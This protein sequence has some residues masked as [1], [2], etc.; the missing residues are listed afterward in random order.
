MVNHIGITN[1][2][3][4]KS[5]ELDTS[6]INLFIGKPNV[7]KSNLLE[8]LSF[9]DNYENKDLRIEN[10][11]NLFYDQDVKNTISIKINNSHQFI[12]FKSNRF[13]SVSL[14]EQALN[15]KIAELK[16]DFRANKEAA[17]KIESISEVL[18]E[19]QS[20]ELFSD[21]FIN[22]LDEVI[23]L[24]LVCEG[25]INSD[26]KFTKYKPNFVKHDFIIKKYIFNNTI[27]SKNLSRNNDYLHLAHPYGE[28][29]FDLLKNDRSLLTEISSFFEE[30][31]YSLIID[32]VS[33][34]AEIQKMIGNIGYK[35]PYSLIADTLQ[36]MVFYIA[37]IR[38]NENTTILLEEPENHSFPPYIRDIAFE[39]INSSNQFFIATHSPYLLNTL[40]AE[41]DSK[42]LSINIVSLKN[43]KT[44]VKTIS[45]KEVS[46]ISNYGI[47]AFFNLNNFE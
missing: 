37:A 14:S 33:N 6:R 12:D 18:S 11:R 23:K 2:K 39:I 42:D 16:L 4:I 24:G 21:T 44:V 40:I 13:R 36:R 9:F 28:N 3:S 43:Y 17:A 31:G 45:E 19:L 35:I 10:T 22:K 5:L 26:G 27:H 46:E 34:E 7:G 20:K 29:I 47:D 1:F 8:A 30:Y 41:A 25:E 38:S 15:S 32:F